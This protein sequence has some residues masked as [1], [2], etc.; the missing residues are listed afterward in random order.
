[1]R[2]R[3]LIRPVLAAWLVVATK[4]DRTQHIEAT[5][6]VQFVMKAG[7]SANGRDYCWVNC[8][9][10]VRVIA[11]AVIRTVAFCIRSA[12]SH[13][14]KGANSGHLS[15]GDSID[16][17]KAGPARDRLLRIRNSL[18]FF[19]GRLP[20]CDKHS[21]SHLSNGVWREVGSCGI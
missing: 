1:V 19:R 17:S 10:R 6:D 11:S 16:N 8:F 21:C 5:Q 14:S 13:P 3:Q 18:R 9:A 12:D 4:G 20:P 2:D 15:K 7:K